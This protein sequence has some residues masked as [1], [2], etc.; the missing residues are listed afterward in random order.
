MQ[1]P[2]LFIA[3]SWS[4]YGGLQRLNRD[5]T[6]FVGGNRSGF[7]CLHPAHPTVWSFLSFVFR[8]LLAAI[9]HRRANGRV[10]VGDAAALPLGILCAWLGGMNLSVTASGLDV[11]YPY[12][13]YQLIIPFCLRRADRVICVS[14]ATA[15]E[16]KKRGVSEERIVIIPCGIDPA[17][18]LP[19]TQRDPHLLATVGRL[20]KRKGVAWFLEHVFLL[21]HQ[22]FPH[23]R[24]VIVGDGPQR[25]KIETII[26]RLKLR[27]AV[28][29]FPHASDAERLEV[30]SEASLFVAPNIHVRGDMEG[31]GIVCL[32]AAAA[33][34][35]IAASSIDGLQDAVIEG[36]TGMFFTPEDPEEC[37]RVI[38][39]M[40]DH[41]MNS[42]T[43]HEAVMNHF[44][45]NKLVPLYHNVFD[46]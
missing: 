41:P 11:I 10:H 4:G 34:L 28:Y 26:R 38:K 23:L 25:K 21:L 2:V 19:H 33:G 7:L 16:V 15:E 22:N 17:S 20:V 18:A 27:D 13:W 42:T 3:R 39:H 43:V 29:L 9:E 14:A 24:Y 32:E 8:S 36:E 35:P 31:F 12:W 5:V 6:R 44:A 30:L 46:S 45:W 40:I 1:R 37:A